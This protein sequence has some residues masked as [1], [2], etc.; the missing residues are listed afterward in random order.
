MNRMFSYLLHRAAPAGRRTAALVIAAV[1]AVSCAVTAGAKGASAASQPASSAGSAMARSGAKSTT[2]ATTKATTTATTAYDPMNNAYRA[3]TATTTSTTAASSTPKGA[4]TTT[5]AARTTTTTQAFSEENENDIRKDEPTAAEQAAAELKEDG[6]PNISAESAIIMDCDTGM[7]L[8]AVNENK[9]MPMASTTKIMTC[10]LT[11]ESGDVGRYITVTE[12]CMD[13][14]DGTRIG[15]KVGDTITIYDLCVGMMM[16]SGN[17]AANTAAVA[18]GGS[19]GNFVSMMNEKAAELGMLNTHFDTPSGLDQFSDGAHYST[20]YDMALLGKYAMQ[21]SDFRTIVS[22]K[23]RKI[24]FGEYSK[25]GYELFSHNYLMEGLR[26]GYEGCDGIKTGVTNLAGQC[27]VS[28][29]TTDQGQH[30]VCASLNNYNRWHDHR[31]LYNYAK[32]LYEQVP[33]DTDIS[34]FNATVVGGKKNT[35]SVE[36]T[37]DETYNILKSQKDTVKKQVVFDRFLYAP[38][39]EG[40]V[41]GRLQYVADGVI[42]KEFPITAT[43]TV[44][45]DTNG[46][47]SDYIK[48]I[49]DRESLSNG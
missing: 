22:A 15:L 12:D 25:H 18:V 49:R 14:L 26:Y 4:K 47:F 21:N 40:D 7:V 17:D 20:A 2:K 38:I 27:L 8:Y 44:E 31:V 39:E 16:Y 13:L 48:A 23:S 6:S 37:P 41:V 5:S 9:Q 24:Y 34:D 46:W 11:L 3:R 10:I 45:A 35:V 43:E 42:I 1:V 36:C 28:H 30:F 29:V 33:V 32:S 19:I